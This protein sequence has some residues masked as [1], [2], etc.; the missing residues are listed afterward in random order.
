VRGVF[1]RVDAESFISYELAKSAS[2]EI[3]K[4]QGGCVVLGVDV[5][6]FGDDPSVIYPRC[7]R[8][9]ITRADRGFLFS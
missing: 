8:D 5:G 9:A 6:R 7:G 2:S 3:L 4:P 1:P